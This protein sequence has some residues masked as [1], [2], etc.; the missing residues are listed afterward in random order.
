M[1]V[2]GVPIGH[3]LIVHAH[4]ALPAAFD[5]KLG[6]LDDKTSELGAAYKNLV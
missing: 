1:K 5:Y 4:V 3:V 2:S 6:V